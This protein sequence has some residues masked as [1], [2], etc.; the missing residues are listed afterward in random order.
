MSR[1]GLITLTKLNQNRTRVPAADRL[2]VVVE[3]GCSLELHLDQLRVI[4]RLNAGDLADRLQRLSLVRQHPAL[5]GALQMLG[6]PGI[7]VIMLGPLG[8]DLLEQ[9][10]QTVHRLD[11]VLHVPDATGEHRS[12]VQQIAP[13]RD[14]RSTQCRFVDPA[15]HQYTSP[16]A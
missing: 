5:N 3:P 6:G 8:V 10:L 15:N 9:Y 12:G 7:K 16:L 11:G 1:V 13:R 4:S 2:P 14:E